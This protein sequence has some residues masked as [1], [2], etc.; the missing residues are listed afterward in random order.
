MELKPKYVLIGLLMVTIAIRLILAFYQPAFTYESY[1]HLRQ[2]EHIT[3]TGLPLYHDELSYGGRDLLFLPLFHYFMAFFDLFLPLLIVAKL[4]PNLLIAFLVVISYLI[5]KKITNNETASLLSAMIAGFLP[6][7]FS[8][9]SFTVESL[10]LPIT[11]LAIYAFL[12]IRA[13]PAKSKEKNIPADL[14]QKKYLYLYILSFLIVSISSSALLLLVGLVIYLLLSALEGKKTDKAELEVIIFSVFFFLWIQF[15]FFKNALLKE[16]I[17][18]IWENIPAGLIASYFPKFSIP[19]ALIMV[20]IIPVLAGIY[21][22]YKS[23]FQLKNQKSF[24]L[25]SFTVSTI[26][27]TWL[28]LIKFEKSLAFFGVVLA[29]LFASFYLELDKYLQKTK[30]LHFKKYLLP[31]TASLLLLFTVIPAINASLQ[32]NM[33]S[34]EE[35]RAFIWLRNNTLARSTILGT[36]EEGHLISYYGQRKNLMDDQFRFIDNVEKRSSDLNSLFTTS[37][38]TLALSISDEYNIDYLVL[39]P[40]AKDKYGIKKFKYSSGECFRPVYKNETKIYR[41]RCK[42]KETKVQ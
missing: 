16:G 38:Q 11:F 13:G 9:N 40:S 36:L 22:V 25:I 18:F 33:P 29:I 10:S 2:V 32:Q 1:F 8:T 41:I 34:E 28:R 3:Q 6:I 42:L 19:Q 12:N 21:V 31:L 23:L 37:F 4:I 5:S 30:L 26:I 20:S 39:T 7:L 35:V 14:K 24:L 27:L 17:F 15:L